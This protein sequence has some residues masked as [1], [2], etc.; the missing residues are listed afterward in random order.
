MGVRTFLIV[1]AA[2]CAPAFAQTPPADTPRPA[3]QPAQPAAQK[4]TLGDPKAR[5]ERLLKAAQL[6]KKAQEVRQKGVP[7]NEMKEALSSAKAK[8]VPPGEM[9]DA[10]DEGSKSIDQHGRIDNFGSFVKSKVNQGLRGRELSAAIRAEHAKR[11]M[12][13]AGK[14]DRAKKP[15]P[16]AAG[17]DNDQVKEKN[18]DKVKNKDKGKGSDK[19]KE[20]DKGKDKDPD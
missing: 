4:A 2:T 17:P 15:K 12:G 13:P 3:G 14:A 6:P 11:G 19:D 1:I 16:T 10:V 8:G 20:K 9:S 5:Q 18:K 7:D